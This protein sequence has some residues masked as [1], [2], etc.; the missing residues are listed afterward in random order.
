[1]KT[2]LAGA[3]AL[4]APLAL[5]SLTLLAACRTVTPAELQDWGTRTYAGT[6]KPAAFKA[7][8]SAVRALGYDIAST[9]AGTF[10]LRTAPKLVNVVASGSSY[11]AQ[12]VDNSMA[13]DIDVSD[14]AAGVVVHATP[15]GYSGGQSIPATK[16]S[17][18]YAKKAFETLFGEIEHD[19]GVVPAAPAGR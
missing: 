15:R 2:L 17:Q 3:R 13:W 7:S 10:Q 8:M 11:G 12:A 6:T 14:S 1:M 19:M 5:L 4:F 16:F 9:D 18:S